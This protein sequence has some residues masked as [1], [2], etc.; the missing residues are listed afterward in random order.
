MRATESNAVEDL[1]MLC[2]LESSKEYEQAAK[3]AI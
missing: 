3:A 2:Y 1:S